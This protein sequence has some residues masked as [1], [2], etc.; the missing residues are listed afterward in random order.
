MSD[1]Q[2]E[3]GDRGYLL[4][5]PED[6]EGLVGMEDAIDAV[7]QACGEAST[8]PIVNAPRR[9]IHSPDGVRV[10]SFPG[11]IPGRHSYARSEKLVLH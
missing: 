2:T 9:R 4:L 6:M 10:S 3:A 8:W 1:N 5:H 7:E 11:G